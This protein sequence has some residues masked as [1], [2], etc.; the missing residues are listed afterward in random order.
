MFLLRFWQMSPKSL[1]KNPR[2]VTPNSVHG[3]IFSY[4]S[5]CCAVA[6]SFSPLC[7]PYVICTKPPPQMARQPLI[8]ANWSCS[9]NFTL[10]SFV[11]ST[12]HESLSICWRWRWHSNMLGWMKCS[13]KWPHMY[14]SCW[15]VTNSVRLHHI[16]ILLS[17]TTMMMTRW[18]CWRNRD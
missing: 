17:T 18:K 14:F 4:L 1:S 2:K 12:L 7:G 6:Q 13:V 15:R 11:T 16:P 9:A 8:C 5:I 10:W 3:I